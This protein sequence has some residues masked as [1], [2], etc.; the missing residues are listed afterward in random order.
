APSALTVGASTNSQRYRIPVRVTGDAPANL[1]QVQALFGDGPQPIADLRAPLRDAGGTACSPLPGGSL[2]G[3]IGIVQRGDSG[4]CTFT[5]KINNAQKAGAVAVLVEQKAGSDL[6]F[7]MGGLRET[8]VPALMIG[9]TDGQALRAFLQR[10][11][12]RETVIERS[13]LAFPTDPNLI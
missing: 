4:E 12:G 11:S 6:L 10:N 5:T 2:A 3:A 7:P 9:S 8:G 13:P 1:Q